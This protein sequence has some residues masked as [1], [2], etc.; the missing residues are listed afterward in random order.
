MAPVHTSTEREQELEKE[1]TSTKDHNK[2]LVVI[3]E[4]WA[5]ECQE[6]DTQIAVIQVQLEDMQ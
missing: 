4:Q 3:N 2:E 1:L 6:K 5:L